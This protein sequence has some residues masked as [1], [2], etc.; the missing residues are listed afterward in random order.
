[1]TDEELELKAKESFNNKLQKDVCYCTYNEEKIYKDGYIS[2]AKENQPTVEEMLKR[3]LKGGYVK[4]G[5]CEK[6]ENGSIW[7]DLR[8][9]PDDL[10]K[11]DSLVR[12]RLMS[13]MEHIC[14]TCYYEPSEDEIGY[15]KLIISFYELNGEWIDDTE[16]IAWCE[17]PKFEVE[18]C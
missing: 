6:K 3:L 17:I 15:G 1:M 12:V 10:P 11:V 9:D 8:K 4:S 13:G 5:I 18:E 16:I 7:H 2:G 14:E